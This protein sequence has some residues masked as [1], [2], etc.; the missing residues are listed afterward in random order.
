M[1]ERIETVVIGGGQAGLATSYS[2]SR[3]GVEHVVL[4]RAAQAASAWR[5]GRWDSFTLITPNWQLRLPGAEYQGDDPDGF[6]SRAEVIAYLEQYVERYRLPVRYDI[7]VTAVEAAHGGSYLVRN[8]GET[9]EAANVV[10]ATG[11]EL[12]PKVPVFSAGVPPE[13][14]QLHSSAYRNPEALPEGAVLV[15]GTGQSG[16]QIAEELHRHGRRVYLSVSGAGRLPRRYRGKDII[17]WLTQVGFFDH[18]LETI[19][20]P[21]DSFVP[22]HVS[23]AGG[24][25]NIN[26]H[27]LAREGVA[28]LGRLQDIQNGVARLSPDLKESLAKA[29]AFEADVLR[30]LD[31]YIAA[32]G[33]D[34][35]QEQSE[36]LRDGY[37]AELILDLD[38]VAS[39]IGSVIWATGYTPDRGLVKLPVFGAEGFPIQQRGVTDYPGLYFIGY[40]FLHKLKS[41]M[42][43]GVGDDAGYIAEHIARRSPPQEVA[44]LQQMSA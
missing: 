26:L 9:I 6:L 15:V 13:V 27:R 8:S 32:R 3:L 38:L 20:F 40:P 30:M 34:A 23:S 5:D 2:L 4:E 43:F 18:T 1:N 19:P 14:T 17:W 12:L 28:L 11:F 35:P 16:S 10:V 21:I 42:F 29:D 31:G 22:P 37:D 39:G 44:A 33:M 7:Q 41:G 24:G 36:I 25:R